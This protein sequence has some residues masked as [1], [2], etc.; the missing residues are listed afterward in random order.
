MATF[1]DI[2]QKL[3]AALLLKSV[4]LDEGISEMPE[5]RS[6]CCALIQPICLCV[7]FLCADVYTHNI[8]IECTRIHTAA[9][10]REG[11]GRKMLTLALAVCA[12][13]LALFYW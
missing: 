13:W 3:K 4:I 12:L 1:H 9:H 5:M 10:V 2:D 7:L 11:E 8:C 6:E